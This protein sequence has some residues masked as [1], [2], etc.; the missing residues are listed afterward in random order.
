MAKTLE[1]IIEKGRDGFYKG[2]VGKAIV[3]SLNKLKFAFIR[4]EFLK[5][6]FLEMFFF[7]KILCSF[8]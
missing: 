8:S 3:N 4:I 1:I 7:I 5:F 6:K 2:E